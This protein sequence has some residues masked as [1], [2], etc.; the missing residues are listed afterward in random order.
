[1]AIPIP[2]VEIGFD[3]V[4]A[5][6]PFLTLDDPIKGQL[7]DPTYPLSGTVFFNVTDRTKSITVQ[8]GKNRALDS[9]E[10]GL[11]NIVLDN[12]DRTFDPEY[13]DSPYFGQVIPK[14]AIRIS[15]GGK[16]I[17]T[18][19]IDDWDLQYTTGGDS[20]ASAAA[21]DAFTLFNTQTLPSGT[22][23]PQTTSQRLNAVLDFPDV[24]WD[25]QSRLIAEGLTPLGADEFP[26][27]GNALEYM[28]QIARSEPGNL[29]MTKGGRVRF[30]NRNNAPT[31]K[32]V[33]FSDDG[34]GIAYQGMRVVYGSELLYNEI[35]LGSQFVGTVIASNA[36]SIAEYGVLNLTQSDLLTNDAEY[37]ENLAIYYAQKYA[38]PEY[39]F[40]SLELVMDD[41]DFTD[42]EK[43]LDL[44]IGDFVEIRFTPN[45][46]PPAIIKYAEIIRIDHAIAPQG[47]IVSL[48][49]STIEKGFWTLSH[50]VLGRLSS[51][52][53]LGF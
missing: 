36:P 1:M 16:R 18:G 25:D 5:N 37:L 42:Q 41:I 32:G 43:I 33:I 28:R 20:E 39:R 7:D 10:A 30:T 47:H 44:E 11:A 53:T 31:D 29:F 4:G 23:T 9:F 24:D 12:S 13:R 45:G 38:Q 15:S 34:S 40:E 52:N 51:G 22:A 26:A 50:P 35:V 19:V 21:S 48:G 14:R 46:I 8:R 2:L 6:A 3:L 49:F 17:F 27:D